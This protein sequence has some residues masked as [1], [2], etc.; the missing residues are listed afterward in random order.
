MPGQVDPN[1]FD[2]HLAKHTL[3]ISVEITNRKQSVVAELVAPLP[4]SK[5]VLVS[6]ES[7]VILKLV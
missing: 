5:K 1:L 7:M 4:H 2:L 6:N 3:T